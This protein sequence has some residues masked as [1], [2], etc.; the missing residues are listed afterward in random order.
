MAA[1]R[2]RQIISPARGPHRHLP[3]DVLRAVAVALVILKHG[4]PLTVD[5]PAALRRIAW[6]FYRGGWV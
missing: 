1:L 3:L 2:R 4:E 5:A 6:T